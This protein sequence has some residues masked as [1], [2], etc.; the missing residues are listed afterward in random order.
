[1]L[2]A[3]CLLTLTVGAAG[4]SFA[5]LRPSLDEIQVATSTLGRVSVLPRRPAA[6]FAELHRRAPELRPV[7]LERALVAAYAARR[8]GFGRHRPFLVVIDHSLPSDARRLWVFNLRTRRLVR[9]ERVAHGEGSGEDRPLYWSNG[10][11]SRA[12]SLGLFVTRETYRGRRGHSLRLIG[13]DP[14]H[15]DRAYRRSLVFH[16][17]GYMTET[18]R[19][20]HGGVFGQSHG[21]PALDPAVSR[22]VIDLL[23]GGTL[24]FVHGPDPRWLRES[25]WLQGR[26]PA[27]LRAWPGPRAPRVSQ[28][29]QVNR[30][31]A[32]EG[33]AAHTTA[34]LDQSELPTTLPGT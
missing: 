1:M 25:S 30:A 17:A 19:N 16:G 4:P 21:C 27:G 8:V 26:V 13:L 10:V 11:D 18:F 24:V 31:P 5:P 9:R 34:N 23:E 15:N 33:G 29:P 6:A 2:G 32:Q 7:V 28:A 14:G 20:T 12:S 3:A 22:E